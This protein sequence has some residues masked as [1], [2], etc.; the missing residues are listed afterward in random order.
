VSRR[1]REPDAAPPNAEEATRLNR[2]WE[3]KYASWK[4]FEEKRPRDG[5]GNPIPIPHGQR[6]RISIGLA[7]DDKP[8]KGKGGK[9][10]K[11][12]PAKRTQMDMRPFPDVGLSPTKTAD[13]RLR[14]LLS[15]PN[16][17][18]MRG[19]VAVNALLLEIV[20][21]DGGTH[22]DMRVAKILDLLI[23]AQNTAYKQ[24]ATQA[25]LAKGAKPVF[26]KIGAIVADIIQRHVPVAQRDTALKELNIRIRDAM[27]TA[28]LGVVKEAQKGD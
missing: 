6:G 27:Q 16:L 15:D 18:D 28:A 11:Q 2:F 10:K 7:E 24:V 14:E 12:L 20:M 4:E 8:K 22:E 1:Q 19:P 9:G 13:E 25:V 5:F 3:G 21:S 17:L 23:K 26:D